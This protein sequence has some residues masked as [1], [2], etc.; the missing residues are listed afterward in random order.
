MMVRAD[1]EAFELL[2][3]CYSISHHIF[4]PR[5]RLYS[6]SQYLSVPSDPVL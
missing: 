1:H 5:C 3:D 6:P 2:T 4:H